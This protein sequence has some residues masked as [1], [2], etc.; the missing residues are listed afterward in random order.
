MSRDVSPSE[1]LIRKRLRTLGR[2][3][4]D[5]RRG[6]PDA[7]HGARVATRRL[8]ELVPVVL[9][10][11]SR[12]KFERKVRR[13]TCALG[14]VRELDVASS[15]LDA[16]QGDATVPWPALAR[17][18]Q[19][20]RQERQRLH[21]VMCS[22][23]ERIDVD[24]LRRRVAAAAKKGKPAALDGRPR[25]AWRLAAAREQAA[26]R[27][28][29]LRIAIENAGGV[30][31]PDRLHEV[32][33]AVKKLRYALELT[34]ELSGSR[35]MAHVRTLTRAQDLLGRMHDLDVLIARVRAVQGAPDAPNLRMSG[36]LDRL[37][38][39]LETECRQL[40]GHYI[41]SRRQLCAICDHAIVGPA[42]RKLLR[43]LAAA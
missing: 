15:I 37:V 31:L 2:L 33:V 22:E 18:K 16:L 1:L 36:D 42:A 39:R 30:Y 19:V 40:H 27:A 41:A 34:R 38:R 5:V 28:T 24:K 8:R 21:T 26:R 4:P 10:G 35:A 7:I 23:I 32:R 20:I 43:R 14:P 25:D 11:S 29:R 9:T 12:R 17:L 13:L 6:H 3:L